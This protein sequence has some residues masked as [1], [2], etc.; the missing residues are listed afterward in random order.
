MSSGSFLLYIF[1]RLVCSTVLVSQS[2][3]DYNVR[4]QPCN[5]D[6]NRSTQECVVV[7]ISGKCTYQENQDSDQDEYQSEVL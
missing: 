1:C 7:H 3:V 2:L 6:E 5:D 4:D